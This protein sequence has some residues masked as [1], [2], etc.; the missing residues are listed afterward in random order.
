MVY[1][2]VEQYDPATDTWWMMPS[3]QVKRKALAA[4]VVNGRIYAIGGAPNAGWEP[5]LSTVE[6]YDP[7][8]MVSVL[9]VGTSL[10]L[11]WNGI[12]QSSDTVDGPNWQELNPPKW[13]YAIDPAQAGPMKFYRAREP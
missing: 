5:A 10:R 6:E 7:K 3:M 9:Q 2:A 13:P 8:P 11:S 12:L 4:A 1:G